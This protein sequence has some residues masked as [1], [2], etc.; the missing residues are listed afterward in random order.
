MSEPFPTDR[1]LWRQAER[2]RA[3]ARTLIAD[4]ALGEDLVQ[5]AWTAALQRPAAARESLGA[6]LAGTLRHL[7]LRARRREGERLAVERRAARPEGQE[8]PE[9]AVARAELQQRLGAAVLALDEPYRSAVILRH[10]D[11]LEPGEIARRQGCSREAA[12][13]RIARG[14]DQLRRRLDAEHGG[15]ERWCLP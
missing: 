2:L 10:F 14:L 12:R 8:G 1:E 3:L 7:A 11:Q 5:D 15:R 6:W 4:P 13:Q 9:E